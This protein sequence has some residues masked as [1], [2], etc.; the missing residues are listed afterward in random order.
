[1]RAAFVTLLS[2][3]YIDRYPHDVLDLPG[4]I[5]VKQPQR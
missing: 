5:Q 1:L 3:L 4:S 2:H